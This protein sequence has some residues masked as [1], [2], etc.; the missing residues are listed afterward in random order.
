MADLFVFYRSFWDAINEMDDAEQ[1]E[2]FHALCRY[3]LN[4]TAPNF[5]STIQRAVFAVMKPV[6]DA[7]V[8][9]RETGKRGGRP[10]KPPFQK[11]ETGVSENEN[12]GFEN[13]KPPFQKLETN[14]KQE[15][16]NKKQEQ[17]ASIEENAADAAL[18]KTPAPAEDPRLDTGLSEIIQRYEDDIGS[19]PRSALDSLQSWR[20][21]LGDELVGLAIGEAAENNA[22]SWRYIDRVLS[23]WQKEGVRT[24]G[25]VQAR[26]ERKT[27]P[28][29]V[30]TGPHY[31]RAE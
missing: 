26:R 15:A 17:E 13:K 3:A 8:T 20:Q 27:S 9:S 19:F 6:I 29:E 30:D 31:R 4:G 11:S 24:V 7:N 16:R 23:S 10:R 25:D 28:A 12:G 1:L 21:A 2:M 5:D 18:K 22:R 14:K